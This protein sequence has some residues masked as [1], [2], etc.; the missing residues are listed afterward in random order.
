MQSHKNWSAHVAL[1]RFRVENS[2]KASSRYTIKPQESF[3]QQDI[4]AFNTTLS[5]DFHPQLRFSLLLALNQTA[6]RIPPLFLSVC[7]L[8]AFKSSGGKAGQLSEYFLDTFFTERRILVCNLAVGLE[9]RSRNV[10]PKS[11][12]SAIKMFKSL[13][14]SFATASSFNLKIFGCSLVCGDLALALFDALI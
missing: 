4:F 13:M 8:I 6:S 14:T 12:F 3:P 5:R 11:E 7:I 1:R 9:E 10:D 2:S